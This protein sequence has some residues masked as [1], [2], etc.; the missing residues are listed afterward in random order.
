M[1]GMY[2][3][4]EIGL[5]IYVLYGTNMCAYPSESAHDNLSAHHDMSANHNTIAHHNTIAYYNKRPR[6][7]P[8]TSM[9][10]IAIALPSWVWSA[11]TSLAPG[12]KLFMTVVLNSSEHCDI[13]RNMFILGMTKGVTGA[14]SYT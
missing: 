6:A 14:S 4:T 2:N 12:L 10:P 7:C 5:Y 1:R 13:D 11:T 8:S 3:G 9:F